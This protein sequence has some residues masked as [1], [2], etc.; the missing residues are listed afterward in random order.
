MFIDNMYIHAENA[1]G[2]PPAAPSGLGATSASASSIELAWADNSSDELGFELQHSIDQSSWNGLPDV[3]ADTTGV[4][5]TGLLS[6]TTYYYR[7]RA[8]N[9]SGSSTWTGVASATTGD[10]PQPAD[11]SLSLSGSKKRGKHVIDLVWSGITTPS[12]DIY[13]D[14]GLLTTVSDTGSYSDNTN[15]KGGI[16]YTYQVCEADTI[17]CSAVESITF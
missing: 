16:T 7:I 3:G 17:N 13:R 15:N 10:G 12:V 4:T 2:S 5:D 8:F 14:N 11:I 1:Q 6:S 9:L